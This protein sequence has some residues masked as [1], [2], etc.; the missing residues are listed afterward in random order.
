MKKFIWFL[1]ILFFSPLFLFSQKTVKKVTGEAQLELSEYRS[2]AD[3]KKEVLENAIKNGLEKEFGTYIIQ[4]N[5]TYIKNS[6][7]GQKTETSTYFNS[8]ANSYVKGE[9][10]GEPKAEYTDLTG[11]RTIDGRTETFTEIK[12]VAE[13]LA[14]EITT[15]KIEFTAF[16]LKC[17]DEKCQTTEFK[18][19]DELYILFSSPVSGYISIFID[20]EG[21]TQCLYPYHNMPAE[22]EGGVPVEAD[23]KYILFSPRPEFNYFPG[24]KYLTV[25]YQLVTTSAIGYDRVFIIFSKSPLNKPSLSEAGRNEEGK[26]IVPRQLKSEDFQKWLIKCHSFEKGSLEVEHIDIT[27]KKRT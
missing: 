13:F 2:R 23:K 14:K 9:M 19:D 20:E 24:K 7:T 4:G 1:I 8:V 27:I 11:K 18:V 6:Q 5:S 17:P 12:C 16:T 3:V 26:V 25:P 15:P 10:V 21:T 22:Y